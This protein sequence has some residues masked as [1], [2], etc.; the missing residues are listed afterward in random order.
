[1]AIDHTDRFG[2]PFPDGNEE[3]A[4]NTHIENLAKAVEATLARP[5]ELVTVEDSGSADVVSGVS[6]A[7]RRRFILTPTRS[8]V[9]RIDV[10]YSWRATGNSAGR[11]ALIVPGVSTDWTVRRAN[12]SSTS[13][14]PVSLHAVTQVTAGVAVNVDLYASTDA[15]GVTRTL[16]LF[17]ANMWVE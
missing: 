1:M 17:R 6:L 3:F 16:S 2:W 8:G 7:L 14:Q 11:D 5:L 10:Y 13:P 9:A 12:N 15:A 4:P